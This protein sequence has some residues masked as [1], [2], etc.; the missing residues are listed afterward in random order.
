[1][2]EDYLKRQRIYKTI[3]LVLLTVFLTFIVTTIYI[4]NKYNLGANEISALL[5]S[6]SSN[7]SLSKSI[8]YIDKINPH[9]KMGIFIFVFGF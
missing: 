8:N 4:T 5:S 3:M 6:S 7:D 1:M 9:V 2:E